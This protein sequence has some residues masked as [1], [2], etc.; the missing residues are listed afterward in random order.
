MIY[1][2]VSERVNSLHWQ[3]YLEDDEEET[4]DV[5][6]EVDVYPKQFGERFMLRLLDFKLKL[7]VN[8]ADDGLIQKHCNVSFLLCT[9]WSV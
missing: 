4:D 6:A 5:E 1:V 7:Q 2:F 8:L 3:R 9:L